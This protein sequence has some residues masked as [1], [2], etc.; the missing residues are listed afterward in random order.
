MIVAQQ[1]EVDLLINVC[2]F[3]AS[4]SIHCSDGAPP[5]IE[6]CTLEFRN[7]KL[8]RVI[9]LTPTDRKWIDDIVKDV[10]EGWSDESNGRASG[11]Q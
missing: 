8:E 9:G 2:F 7:M 3:Y 5:Q 10:N 1:K 4:S 6:T 11:M